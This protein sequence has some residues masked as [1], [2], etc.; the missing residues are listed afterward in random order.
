MTA[1]S[2]SYPNYLGGLN[3]QPDELKKPGQLVEALNVIPDP[4]FGLVRRP[5]FE[6]IGTIDTIDPVGSWFEADAK[7]PINDDYIYFGCV[8]PDGNIVIFNQDGEIQTVKY[9]NVGIV[10]HQDYRYNPTTAKLKV[11]DNNGKETDEFDVIDPIQS[12]DTVEG[13]EFDYL[14]NTVEQLSYCISKRHIIFANAERVPT[15]VC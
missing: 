14:S 11:F 5:G 13:N 15:I 1:V 6:L 2:Q 10:P 3:E 12:T 7:N 4:V 9:V 8:N